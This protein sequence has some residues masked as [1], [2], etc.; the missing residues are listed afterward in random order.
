[1]S[2][3]R[4]DLP[5]HSYFDDSVA[6]HVLTA[7]AV[8]EASHACLCALA[9]LPMTEMWVMLHVR[10]EQTI[11]ASG[12]VQLEPEIADDK[13]P[14]WLITSA[15]GQVGEAMWVERTKPG[16]DQGR[17]MAEAQGGA[18]RDFENFHW[19][20]RKYGLRISWEAAQANARMLLTSRWE[21]VMSEAFKLARTGRRDVR[22]LRVS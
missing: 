19:V 18:C 7:A 13:V 10:D 1:M 15:G 9:G 20:A 21:W 8:H 22:G 2:E 16:Y 6:R 5:G 14:N 17:A 12:M 11:G 3:Y 4:H